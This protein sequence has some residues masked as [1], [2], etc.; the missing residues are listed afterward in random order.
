MMWNEPGLSST[1]SPGLSSSPSF[2][3][4]IFITLPSMLHFMDLDAAGD[5][6][7]A[8]DQPVRRGTRCW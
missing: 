8:A 4:R 2:N 1:V 5:R 6:R 3:G 7:S